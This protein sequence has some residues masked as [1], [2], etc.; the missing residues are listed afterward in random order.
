MTQNGNGV[1]FL[2]VFLTCYML[3]FNEYKG[4]SSFAYFQ[5]L[6]FLLSVVYSIIVINLSIIPLFYWIIFVHFIWYMLTGFVGRRYNPTEIKSKKKVW[7]Y[8]SGGG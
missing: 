6:P 7:I 3:L 4:I 1:R 2:W 5:V 8:K